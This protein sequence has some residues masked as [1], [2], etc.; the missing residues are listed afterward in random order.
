MS[1]RKAAIAAR[2]IRKRYGATVAVDGVSFEVEDGEFFGILGPN[3]AGKTTTLEIVEGLREPDSGE[4]RVLGLPSWPRNP[5]LLPLIGVQMQTSAFFERLTAT[6]QIH[7]LARLYGVPARRGDELLERF[8]LAHR[9]RTRVDHLSGGEAQRLS[10]ACALVHDPRVLFLDEPTAGLD[11][12]ARRN[13]WDLVREINAS[14][15][16]VV[17]TT[18]YIEEAE[19][20]CDRVAIVDHGRVLECDRPQALIRKVEAVA[21]I[22]VQAGQIDV[23]ELRKR[24]PE[25]S[26]QQ[27][28]G[29]LVIATRDP[30]PVLADLAGRGALRELTMRGATLEDAFLEL[31]GRE[32]R[33]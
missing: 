10:I 22:T 4:A 8:G 33:A 17:L 18:H 23:E 1:D 15:R 14:G 6:E 21:R 28:E 24:L 16:T 19:E 7:T 9:A 26:V 13:L 30:G 27:N 20:L 3:G 5:A 2:E 32:Y 12:Q 11:P 25:A 31:T 29:S